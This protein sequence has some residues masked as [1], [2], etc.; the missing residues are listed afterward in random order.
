MNSF[1]PVDVMTGSRLHFGLI[2]GTPETGWVFG[3]FAMMLRNPGWHLRLQAAPS[4]PE[5]VCSDPG[6][7]RRIL[8]VLA[9][10][11]PLPGCDESGIRHECGIRHESGIRIECGIRIEVL[12][13]S[14]LHAGL[15]AGTQ[16]AL[17]VA[18]GLEV[19]FH[20]RAA[21]SATELAR[22]LGRGSRSGAGTWGFFRGGY[23][24]DYG[25]P[26]AGAS[27][28]A[29][30]QLPVP[31]AWRFV[32]VWPK[33]GA[34]L[35]GDCE[36]SFFEQRRSMSADAISELTGL[37]QNRLIPAVR[38]EDFALYA[39]SVE[40]YG[41]A[42]GRFYAPAQGDVFSH[43]GMGR[44]VASLQAAG[45]RGAAQS[46]WGPGICIPA[47]SITQARRIQ[48]VIEQQSDVQD[49]ELL[50]T[51]ALNHGATIRSPAPETSGAVRA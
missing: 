1:T 44:L 24:V 48:S 49:Y 20:A 47:C 38:R 27:E 37:I 30:L 29:V 10:L 21:R 17:A 3:G 41:R 19:V 34:G 32:V 2:C 28:R 4:G 13:A 11:R 31:D 40:E 25:I 22:I 45:I 35:S 8:D 46:S 5:I 18:R 51:E 14:R 9:R 42:I 23:L 16:L 50:V 15:G 39:R 7:T 36:H 26:A 6:V 12:R 33:Q 43:P